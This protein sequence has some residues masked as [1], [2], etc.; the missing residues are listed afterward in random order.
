[1]QEKLSLKLSSLLKKN[2]NQFFNSKILRHVA[3]VKFR[4]AENEKKQ[5][6]S[7]F[8]ITELLFYYIFQQFPRNIITRENHVLRKIRARITI[9]WLPL[10]K[11]FERVNLFFMK[12]L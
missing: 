8:A 1:M 6:A 12:N 11:G 4:F 9:F 2:F 10:S 5:I 7:L 3:N